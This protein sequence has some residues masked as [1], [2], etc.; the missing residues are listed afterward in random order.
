MAKEP[1]QPEGGYLRI[2]MTYLLQIRGCV[3]ASGETGIETTLPMPKSWSDSD[4]NMQKDM[5]ESSMGVHNEITSN[6]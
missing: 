5:V 4:E 6:L 2:T 1:N 3:G